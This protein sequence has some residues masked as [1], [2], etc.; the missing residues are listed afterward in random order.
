MMFNKFGFQGKILLIFIVIFASLVTF[1]AVYLY[2]Y[3][4]SSLIRTNQTNL[5]PVVHKI[6]DQIDMLYQQLGNAAINYTNN[7]ENLAL[8]VDLYHE[9]DESAAAPLVYKTK[10]AKN[11]NAIYSVVSQLYKIVIFIPEKDVFFTYIRD[12][13]LVPT[14]PE[15]Y[16]HPVQAVS[17]R[18]TR[19]PPH[20]DDWSTSPQTVI[21]VVSKFSTPYYKDFGMIELQLPYQALEQIGLMEHNSTGKK[22]LIF[23]DK[24][25]L[26]FPYY[27]EADG[28][29]RDM[30]LRLIEA[31]RDHGEGS[32]EITLDKQSFL[33]SSFRSASAGWTT[34]ITDDETIL[35][36]TVRDYGVIITLSSSLLLAAILA[37]YYILI[38]RLTRPLK[39][40][41]R[42]VRAISLDN[43]SMTVTTAEPNEFKLLHQSFSDM[44]DKIRESINNE[45][46]S[47]IRETEAHSSALQA[48]INPHFIYNTLSVITAHCEDSDAGVAAEMCVRLAGMM[49]YTASMVSKDVPLPEEIGHSVDYLEL[50]KL[51]YD[52]SLAYDIH[53]PEALKHLRIPKLTLQPFVE[54]CIDHG[55]EHVLPPWRIR[56]WGSFASHDHWEITIEDNGSGFKPNQL[57]E[58]N[59][60][61]SAYRDNFEKGKL[62]ANLQI[63]GLGILNTYAR[64]LIHFG[65]R[66]YLRIT[67]L[68][69][70][71][72]KIHMGVQGPLEEEQHD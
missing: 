26:L 34:V 67:N 41:T 59:R 17:Q 40:L 55:F 62:L 63:G 39:E 7:Q 69:E 70:R 47:R 52:D 54:N 36:Q 30:A 2:V 33:F 71:G 48:Q 16:A 50:M 21:S 6:S 4:K 35:R 5:A 1:F 68:E 57:A 32:G 61:L 11:L 65:N 27:G 66:F 45:Y 24:G 42:K 18:F 56:I 13:P 28:L 31:I 9:A 64:L 3:M 38:Q 20:P 12:E 46:E 72:C 44:V 25:S 58:I 10:L 22:V 60:Q 43:L 29:Q 49:R 37:L 53:L 8:M 51:Q 19:I 14:I 15:R 23:D